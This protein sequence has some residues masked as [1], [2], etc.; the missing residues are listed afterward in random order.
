M[1]I[2]IV[3]E[4]FLPSTD[5]IV[6]R[7]TACIRWLHRDGYEVRIVAPDLG[8]KEFDGAIVQGVPAYAFP[9][10][11]SKK[12][13]FPNRIVKKY[14]ADFEPDIVHVVNPAVVGYS[15]VNYAKSLGIPLIASYHT[16]IPQYMSY[17]KL[18]KLNWLM[19]WFMKKMHNKADLNLC[20][21]QTVLEELTEKGFKRMLVWKR[22]VDTEQFHPRH[23]TADMRTRLSGGQKDKILLLYVGRLAAEKEIEKIR[24]I[25]TESNRFCLAIVGDGPHRKELEKHFKGTQTVFTGF[26]HGEKLASAFASADAFVFPSTTET[27]GLVIMEAMASGLPVVAAESGPTKEQ[28]T[29]RRN[30]LLY[31]SK[32]PTS[33]KDTVRQLEDFSFRQQLAQQ[34]VADVSELG[35]AA[36]AEQIG[37]LY[38][39]IA[40]AKTAE[41]FQAAE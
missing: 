30:G 24:E 17:Y 9:F 8:V 19:W 32:D 41:S 34:A 38:S 1:K 28:L 14:M 4:T 29:D 7:L 12:F 37:D 33:F 3:T 23:Y 11:R 22:G 10:Y 39:Q 15:G 6:T 13:A 21:S 35:W 26:I 20:T 18:G 2:M 31:D 25:L 40:K 27:L 5:G 36:A 16:N